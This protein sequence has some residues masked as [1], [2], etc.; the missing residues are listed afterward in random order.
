MVRTTVN[1]KAN[2]VQPSFERTA[3]AD[4]YNWRVMLSN[5]LVIT[6][7]EVIDSF[8]DWRILAPILVLTLLFPALA[9]LLAGRWFGFIERY[10]GEAFVEILGGRSIPF[11]LMVVGFFPISISLVIALETFVGEKERRSLEPLLST[12]LTNTELYVGKTLAAMIPPLVASYAGMT[13]YTVMQMTGTLSWR[14]TPALLTQ[15]YLLTTVQALVMIAGAVVVSS[16]TT[17]TRAANLLASFVIIP[18]T[19]VIQAEAFV[20]FIAPN[21]DSPWGIPSLWLT[22][23]G[24]AVVAGLLLRVGNAVFNREELLG[25]ALDALD[26]RGTVVRMWRNILAV[27]AHLT[28]ARSVG[29]WYRQGVRMA[30]GS[31]GAAAWVTLGC[32]VL[33]LVAGLIV[34]QVEAYQLPASFG[35][36]LAASNALDGGSQVEVVNY[37]LGTNWRA[38]ALV[39]IVGLF[40]FGVMALV[41][42]APIFVVM[43]YLLTQVPVLGGNTNVLYAELLTHGI[44]ELPILF[45]A[46]AAA[47]RLGAIIT[48]PPRQQTIGQAWMHT[49]GN[50]MKI[51]IGVV[52]PSV[53]LATLIETYLTPLVIAAVAGG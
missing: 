53:L 33:A 47:L 37:I 1:P 15:I 17:S 21:A 51:Y 16:Q 49:F 48:Q 14:P 23:L 12:P 38:L 27:D 19:L 18:M 22:A 40:T 45:V 30:L 52:V 8:R 7:R 11:L 4:N 39:L 31:L 32:M 13:F 25:R 28:P 44:I 41:V 36:A 24:M 10:G 35:E 6:R 9:N 50:T 3:A 46:T 29:Q 20:M 34:G 5:A 43:G 2:T 42:A 26:L